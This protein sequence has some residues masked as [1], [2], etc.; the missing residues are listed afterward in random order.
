MDRL[1]GQQLSL[2]ADHDN[3]L[4]SPR[5]D[6]AIDTAPLGT[7][8]FEDIRSHFV[9][10]ANGGQPGSIADRV[11]IDGGQ[12][13]SGS[14]LDGG[15]AEWKADR[16]PIDGGQAGWIEIEKRK[17]GTYKYRRWRDRNGIKRSQYL[18]TVT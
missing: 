15:Q 8:S 9:D 5:T 7:R 14:V 6:W 13:E 12:A 18:G 10:R 4:D 2:I 3:E 17:G 16:V 1:T 11:P